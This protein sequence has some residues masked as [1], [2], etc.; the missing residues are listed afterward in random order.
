LCQSLDGLEN[1]DRSSGSGKTG[2]ALD[3]GEIQFERLNSFRDGFAGIIHRLGCCTAGF[4]CG[5]HIIGNLGLNT[6]Q[7]DI[8]CSSLSIRHSPVA[9]VAEAEAPKL[10]EEA[11]GKVTAGAEIAEEGVLAAAKATS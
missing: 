9:A 1:L 8:R 10:P 3:V 2:T 5:N 7:R 4:V 6:Y 11:R